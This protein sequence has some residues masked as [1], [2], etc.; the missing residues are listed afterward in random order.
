MLSKVTV[1]ARMM[2][3]TLPVCIFHEKKRLLLLE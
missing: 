3:L 1:V 2:S